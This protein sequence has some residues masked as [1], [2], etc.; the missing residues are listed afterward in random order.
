MKIRTNHGVAVFVKWNSGSLFPQWWECLTSY[1]KL[2]IQ[3][4]KGIQTSERPL[5]IKDG[6]RSALQQLKGLRRCIV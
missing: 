3:D 2:K 6:I 5:I 4:K 1:T